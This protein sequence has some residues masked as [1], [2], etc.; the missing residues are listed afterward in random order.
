MEHKSH[1]AFSAQRFCQL[2]HVSNKLIQHFTC[3]HA[4]NAPKHALGEGV[5]E[6]QLKRAETFL[7]LEF[8]VS[9]KPFLEESYEVAKHK[10]LRS[11]AEA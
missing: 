8:T 7:T 5:E 3:V 2:K 6:S 1:S 9:Q 4:Q 11:T 10:Q